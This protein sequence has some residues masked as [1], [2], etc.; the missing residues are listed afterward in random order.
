[1][2]Q[3]NYHSAGYTTGKMAPC[4]VVSTTIRVLWGWI[5]TDKIPYFGGRWTYTIHKTQLCWG[6]HQG[7][8]VLIH[9]LDAQKSWGWM[10]SSINYINLYIWYG[11]IYI[12]TFTYDININIYIHI[13]V[14]ISTVCWFRSPFISHT[15]NAWAVQPATSRSFGSRG[16]RVAIDVARLRG[17]LKG[18]VWAMK[19]TQG[20]WKEAFEPSKYPEL[21]GFNHHLYIG[22]MWN[23]KHQT[24][25]DTTDNWWLIG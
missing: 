17:R 3:L 22:S 11:Y 20:R 2:K 6:V 8:R 10:V 16:K 12:H 5:K 9:S 21:W 7:I 14:S 13:C 25:G 15:P 19:T 18:S 1:M 4:Q 23:Y 24:Y